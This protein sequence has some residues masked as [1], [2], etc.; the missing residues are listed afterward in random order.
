MLFEPASESTA[1]QKV[2]WAKK[3][4]FVVIIKLFFGTNS[5]KIIRR[6]NKI[7]APALAD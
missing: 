5:C 1:A 7:I 6:E 2:S 3:I 4:N